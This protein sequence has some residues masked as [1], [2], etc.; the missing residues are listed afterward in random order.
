MGSLLRPCPS[1][2]RSQT[3]IGALPRQ[4]PHRQTPPGRTCSLPGCPLLA[5]GAPGGPKSQH[6]HRPTGAGRP[7]SVTEAAV[8][9]KSN[10]QT[11][12]HLSVLREKYEGQRGTG[13][14]PEGCPGALIGAWRRGGGTVLPGLSARAHRRGSPEPDGKLQTAS[15]RLMRGSGGPEGARGTRVTLPENVD[16][17]PRCPGSSLERGSGRLLR[18]SQPSAFSLVPGPRFARL[19]NGV[20]GEVAEVGLG[21]SPRFPLQ[22]TEQDRL[23]LEDA[24]ADGEGGPGSGRT[25]ADGERRLAHSGR[26]AMRLGPARP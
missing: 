18:S 25:P 24:R 11:H 13:F 6:L 17:G 3:L 21:L 15:S 2:G 4:P 14:I 1:G 23:E 16:P 20:T 5:S 8:T 26:P 10:R 9:P 19:T 7:Q 22:V 12:T